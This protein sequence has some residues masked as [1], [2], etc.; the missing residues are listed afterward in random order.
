MMIEIV[1][2]TDP[3]NTDKQQEYNLDH[4]VFLQI[5]L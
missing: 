1:E 3:Y 4:R 2:P 5:K